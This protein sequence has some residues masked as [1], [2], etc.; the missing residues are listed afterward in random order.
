MMVGMSV[1]SQVVRTDAVGFV[2]TFISV[3]VFNARSSVL[4][5]DVSMLDLMV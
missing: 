3:N 5:N 2:N 1:K 4:L